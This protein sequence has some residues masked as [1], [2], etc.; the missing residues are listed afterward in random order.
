MHDGKANTNWAEVPCPVPPD[1]DITRLPPLIPV[2]ILEL[3][4]RAAV[5]YDPSDERWQNAIIRWVDSRRSFLEVILPEPYLKLPE[6]G[7]ND[8]GLPDK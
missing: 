5:P 4:P 1:F 2:E 7:L 8:L 6:T 3:M